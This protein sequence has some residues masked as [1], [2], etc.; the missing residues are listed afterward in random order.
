MRMKKVILIFYFLFWTLG[1]HGQGIANNWQ[2]GYNSSVLPKCYLDFSSG[3][4]NSNT[5]NRPMNFGPTCTS[6]CNDSGN[7]LFYTNGVYIANALHDTMMNGSNLSPSP[8]T[9]S[10][11][12]DGLPIFAGVLALPW[13]DNTNKYLLIHETLNYDSNINYRPKQILYSVIDMNLDFGKGGVLQKN[14]TLINDTL[15]GGMLTACKHA[16]GRDWWILI[17]KYVSDKYFRILFTPLGISSIDT[18]SVGGPTSM[19]G[20]QASFSPDGNWFVTYDNISKVRIYNFDRCNGDLNNYIYYPIT[21]PYIGGGVSFS[22]NSSKLYLSNSKYLYQFDLLVT[23]IVSSQTLIG[24]FDSTYFSPWPP[25]QTNFWYHMLGPDGRIYI[26]SQASVVDLHVINSP[27]NIGSSCDFQAHSFYLGAFNIS[28]FP[29]HINYYLGCDTL[30]GCTCLT[31]GNEEI[32]IYDFKISLLPNPSTGIFKILY[33]LPKNA[34]GQLT[35]YDFRKRWNL[36][37]SFGCKR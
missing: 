1:T 28:T 31:T 17:K 11:A 18:I 29:N 12:P 16:N 37:F 5:F 2:L 24:E 9:T 26:N 14:T 25:F 32:S 22:S 3:S 30:L 33:L 13:P 4:P 34:S 19:F 36:Y 15:E 21:D 7:L 20:G 10:W 35:I 23:N 8:F 27:N 6:I